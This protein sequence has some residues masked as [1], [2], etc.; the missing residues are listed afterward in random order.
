MKT[1]RSQPSRIVLLVVA[2][3][4]AAAVG[5]VIALARGGGTPTTTSIVAPS[6]GSIGAGV[7]VINADLAFQGA[8]AAGTGM[9]LTPSGEV[10]TNNHVISGATK[11]D[12][13]VPNTGHSYKARVVG[14]DRTADVALLQ[15]QGASGLKTVSISSA[16]V[17]VGAK[18]TAAGN[19]GGDGRITL[20]TGTVTALEQSITA[21]DPTGASEHL[22]GLIETNAGIR[23]GDSGGP[24]LNS[25]GQVV[26]MDTAASSQFTFHDVSTT[27][28]F[29]IPMGIA[30]SIA[31]AISSGNASATVHIGTTAFLGI[32]AVSAD[33][34]GLGHGGQA[35]TSSG[36]LIVSVVSG[37]PAASSGL[38]GGDLITAINGQ[39]VASPT[40]LTSLLLTKKPGAK[41]KV[42]YVDQS[43]TSHTAAVTLGSGPPQ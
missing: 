24:L 14:Y 27:D 36:A 38:S 19:A 18:V 39:G 8:A 42:V 5:A 3:L 15:L 30:H 28:A 35:A 26:G 1:V 41:V 17:S 6:T 37:G 29:A 13:V 10:L 32:E 40:A 11:I 22:T 23:P 21:S 33:V 20:A 2:G 25:Q 43:G 12:V 9:V 4:L 34:S 31:D 16:T 7:V